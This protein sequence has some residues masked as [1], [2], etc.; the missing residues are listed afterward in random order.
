V[1]TE[2]L[3]VVSSD[4]A[5]KPSAG[6]KLP[7]LCSEFGVRHILLSATINGGSNLARVQAIIAHAQELAVEV[8]KTPKGTRYRLRYSDGDR[9]R[10]VLELVAPTQPK[11]RGP[12]VQKTF[13]EPKPSES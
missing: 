8:P 3:I 1:V 10:T 7:K 6:D 2:E 5:K 4:R 12:A 9:H 11:P 13:I